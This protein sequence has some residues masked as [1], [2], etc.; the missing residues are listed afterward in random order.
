MLQ[1]MKISDLHS[2]R[3]TE[4]QRNAG[5]PGL[6]ILKTIHFVANPLF[7]LVSLY[8]FHAS[9][10]SLNSMARALSDCLRCGPVYPE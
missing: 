9:L 5:I 8:D 10:E 6:C 2:F 1:G 3:H 7:H 4:F